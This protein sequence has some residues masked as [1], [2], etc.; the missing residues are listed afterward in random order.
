[1][2]QTT[3]TK[4]EFIK[5]FTKHVAKISGKPIEDCS[6]EEL[7]EALA[8]LVVRSTAERHAKTSL[9]Y[10]KNQNK[11]VYYLSMEFLIG[12]L[13]ENYLINLGCKEV[14]V[15][16]LKDLGLDFDAIAACER[17]PGLG[18]GGLG[19]L[20]AC[21]LD[22]M[23][24]TEI[25]GFGM[26][27][28]FK[29]GLFRQKIESGYQI[30]LPD[31]WDI[32]GFPWGDTKGNEQVEV[33]F[34]GEIEKSFENGKLSFKHKNY[35]PVMAVPVDVPIIGWRAEKIHKLRLWRSK[36]MK[37]TVDMDAFNHGQ[38]DKA[39]KQRAD[40]E[41]LTCI[42]YPNDNQES[43]KIL[44][45][46]QEYLLVAASLESIFRKYVETYG[47]DKWNE[48]PQHIS[49]HINDTHPALAVPELMRKLMDEQ[50]L[51]WDEAWEITHGVISFTNHT[52]MPEALEKWPQ[53]MLKRLLPRIYMIIEEI[54]HRWK[55]YLHR[56]PYDWHQMV[57]ATE[58]IHN[59]EVRMAQMSVIG[60]HSVNGVAELHSEILKKSLFKEFFLIYPK[61]FNN[62]TNGIS[63]RRFLIQ[64]NPGLADL[65]T[66]GLGSDEW[67]SDF[68]RIGDLL[69]YKD[70]SAFIEK[71]AAVKHENKVRL[72]KY[73][74]DT[75]E[76]A[77]D[78][79]SVFDIQV[80]RIHAYKRQLLNA[81]KV[82]NLYN[83]L[84]ANP[85]KKMRPYTFIF[86]GKSAPGYEFAKESIKFICSVAD[87]VNSDPD[88]NKKMK[89]VFIENFCVSN[90]QLIYP[91]AD[92]S[93]QIS[94]AGKEASGTGNMKFM[95]NGAITLGTLDGAN[96]EIRNLVGD[97]N[98]M[99]FGM[100]ADEAANFERYGGYSAQGVVDFDKRV[101]KITSQLVD[102]FF[103]R[104]GKKFWGIYEALLRSNDQFF[105]LKDFDAYIKAF[106]ELDSIYDDKLHWNN[107]SLVNIA[108]SAY[109]SSDRTVKEYARDIWQI[110]CK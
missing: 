93:E 2:E 45:V 17:D 7:Y 12:R 84:K 44:R 16:G 71:L 53:E 28:Y 51:E 10:I 104:S 110:P 103:D 80:K 52:V 105:V 94:T 83:E 20:A 59:G 99:I 4:E 35:E 97:D 46:K 40:I 49:I 31:D 65:I 81:F 85:N 9:S 72:A 50:G 96:V 58:I 98:I 42:L 1:M 75:Q 22:S 41:A 26:G 32:N 62:K 77:V 70:D 67:M 25:P 60:S 108:K 6:N 18:N 89:V 21:F 106:K 27:L 66:E 91:A 39:M 56:F 95:M 79:D 3:L 11:K 29:F 86:A 48:M 30:E 57:E 33:H 55:D 13:L 74:A 38:Y 76:I 68:D 15:E 92:I 54:D 47:H 100:N 23:A 73:I 107:M 37:P 90:A 43:G 88:V 102:G 14:V 101:K 82:L 36:P 78:P 34:G 61:R 19:R 24:S 69:K 109:F 87:I 63:H 8:G 5:G 64:A